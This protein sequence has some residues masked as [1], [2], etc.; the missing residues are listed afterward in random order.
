ML[1]PLNAFCLIVVLCVFGYLF[2][3][4]FGLWLRFHML[5]TKAATFGGV[6]RGPCKWRDGVTC[7]WRDYTYN[8]SKIELDAI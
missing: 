8:R 6:T 7:K 2:W 4:S 5:P 1:F 3:A